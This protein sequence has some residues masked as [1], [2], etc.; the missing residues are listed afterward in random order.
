MLPTPSRLPSLLVQLATLIEVSAFDGSPVC[1]GQPPERIAVPGS[2]AS[3]Q[4]LESPIAMMKFC[5]QESWIGS[6]QLVMIGKP[7]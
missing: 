5:W 6:S 4:Q 7:S 2:R 1:P 3:H